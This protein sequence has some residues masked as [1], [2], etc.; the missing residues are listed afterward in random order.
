[1]NRHVE[2]QTSKPKAVHWMAKLKQQLR[3]L[4]IAL[5]SSGG[6]QNVWARRTPCYLFTCHFS[7][8]R[9][10]HKICTSSFVLVQRKC[11]FASLPFQ[12]LNKSK[13]TKWPDSSWLEK[14]CLYGLSKKWT[15]LTSKILLSALPLG[16]STIQHLNK[17]R[18]AWYSQGLNNRL[19]IS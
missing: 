15:T 19:H 2:R 11:E 17:Q 9:E 6:I 14:S 13:C 7:Q 8:L 1:M 10:P 18:K 4:Y 5:H 12:L 3:N 16:E